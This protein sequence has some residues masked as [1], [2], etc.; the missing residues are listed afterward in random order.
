MTGEETTVVG[1]YVRDHV[2]GATMTVLD[3][4]GHCPN[5]S[6]PDETAEAIA[7]FVR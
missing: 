6:A 1:E 4:I 2:P 7:A 3:T 5:L